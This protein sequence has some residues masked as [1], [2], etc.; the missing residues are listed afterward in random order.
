YLNAGLIDLPASVVIKDGSGC[1]MSETDYAYDESAYPN[2]SYEGTVGA[3]PT[4]THQAVTTPRG[5]LT[6]VTKLLFDHSSCN[7][8]TQTSISSHTK[9]YDTGEANQVMDPL[10][11]TTTHSYD[12]AYAGA[13]VTNT[14]SPSTNGVAHC[15]SA[16]YD[17]PTGLVTSFTNENAT[18]QASGNTP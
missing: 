3:L 16:T 4:G 5:N 18:T 15:V 9:W 14:C 13:L 8:A 10:G 6:T 12:P 11:H 2:V 7:P 17:F 1:K